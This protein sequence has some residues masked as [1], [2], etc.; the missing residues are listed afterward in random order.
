MK[1]KLWHQP[2][3][4]VLKKQQTLQKSGLGGEKAVGDKVKEAEHSE[5]QAKGSG[6]IFSRRIT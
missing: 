2:T 5:Y 1:V 3:Q 6:F 4:V